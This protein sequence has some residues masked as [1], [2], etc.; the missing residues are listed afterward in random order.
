[1]TEDR[2]KQHLETQGRASR[3]HTGRR[4]AKPGSHQGR[5]REEASVEAEVLSPSLPEPE[6]PPEKPKKPG[7]PFR[8]DLLVFLLLFASFSTSRIVSI[9]SKTVLF[10]PVPAPTLQPNSQDRTS[11]TVGCLLSGSDA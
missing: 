9:T 11:N 7:K 8:W 2:T 10:E 5:I 3:S 4:P 1:M 6:A